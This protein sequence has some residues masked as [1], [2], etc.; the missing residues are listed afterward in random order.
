[1]GYL[2]S[3]FKN[4]SQV[5]AQKD[6]VMNAGLLQSCCT[7][8]QRCVYRVFFPKTTFLSMFFFL[9]ICLFLIATFPHLC[10]LILYFTANNFCFF[11]SNFLFHHKLPL[12]STLGL[13]FYSCHWVLCLFPQIVVWL[14]FSSLC[15]YPFVSSYSLPVFLRFIIS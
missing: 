5:I 9:L 7:G 8:W 6:P 10:F 14:P 4:I 2:S 12:P 11:S 15:L 13:L 1:M 3:S